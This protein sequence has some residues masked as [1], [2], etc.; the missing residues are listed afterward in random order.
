MV[1]SMS[2]CAALCNMRKQWG[3]SVEP[4]SCVM[5]HP[6]T[7]DVVTLPPIWWH[8]GFTLVWL[9]SLPVSWCHFQSEVS[10]GWQYA[11]EHQTFLWNI[12]G[13]WHFQIFWHFPSRPI[14]EFRY[15]EAGNLFGWRRRRQPTCCRI[16]K[17]NSVRGWQECLR[18]LRSSLRFFSFPRYWLLLFC[19]FVFLLASIWCCNIATR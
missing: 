12:G 3:S 18:C 19:F 4:T 7:S 1:E 2:H 10:C 11:N 6:C 16:K 5:W 15:G 8:S 13:P 17:W 9:T 14:G